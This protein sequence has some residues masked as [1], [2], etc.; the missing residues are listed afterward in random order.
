MVHSLDPAFLDRQPVTHQLLSTVREIGVL[1]GK[2]ELYRQQSPQILET[3]RQVA[4]IQSTE[5]S[6]RIE[7][8]VA[9]PQRIEEL[10]QQK[11]APANRSEQEIAGYRDVLATIHANHADMRLTPGLVRQMH[12]DLYKFT[13]QP[14]GEWKAADN[15]IIERHPDGTVR[16]RFRPTPAFQTADAME[17]LHGSL[18]SLWDGQCYDRLLVIAA[19]VLDFL[20]IHPFPDGNGRMGRLLTLLLLC[21]SGYGVGRYVSLE[22]VVEDNRDGYY[23]ALESSSDHWHEGRHSVVPWWEY[24]LGVMLLGAY[25]ELERRAGMVESGRGAKSALVLDVVSR[26][27]GPFSVGELRD[28]CPSVGIDLIRRV[29]RN[30][31]EA[32]RLECLGRGPDAQWRRI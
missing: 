28:R 13:P 22:K 30:E 21:Q 31:R 7:G 10:V 15:E 8:V 23:A 4:V 2:E 6:N 25:R 16:T 27:Q 9:P 17:R 26:M 20:C 14:G 19:Y 24:F 3:L 29:L 12:R 1:R 11:A 5:S 32:G 18:R